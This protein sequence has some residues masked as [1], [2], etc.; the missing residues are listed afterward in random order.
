MAGSMRVAKNT[1]FLYVRMVF[2]LLV[3]LYISRVL[4]QQLGVVDYGLYNV[5][6]GIVLMLGFVNSTAAGATSRFLTFSLAARDKELY[7]YRTIFSL[8]FFI[9][10]AIAVVLV[11]VAETAGVW[12]FDHYLVIPPERVE[13]GWWVLQLSIF[14]CLIS[15]T[16]VPYNSSLIAHEHMNVYALVGVFEAVAKLAIAYALALS[17]G[18]KLIVYALLMFSLTVSVSVFYRVYCI[19][20]FGNKCRLMFCHHAKVMKMLLGYSVWDLVGCMGGIARSQGVNIMLN[21]FFGPA[22]NAAR[23]I[24]GQ[25]E[26]GLNSFTGNFQ[27]A[28]RPAIIKRYAEGDISGMLRLFYVTCEFSLILYSLLAVPILLETDS[29]LAFWLVNPPEETAI[30]I[31]LVILTY[32]AASIN[33]AIG[34]G[35]HATGDVKRLN[36]YAGTKM[37]PEMAAIWLLLYWG[38]PAWSA[39]AVMLVS[40]TLIMWVDVWVLKLN[41]PA[42]RFGEFFQRVILRAGAAVAVPVLISYGICMIL[43]WDIPLLRLILISIIYWLLLLPMV[44]FIGM[45]NEVRNYVRGQLRK[46]FGDKNLGRL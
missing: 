22:V 30:F 40:S 15:F 11:I 16:Q 18:D 23:A 33:S 14:T 3:Q 21:A 5:I 27:T 25:V 1:L 29:V 39:F 20:S 26:N 37:F 2:V 43:P 6:G 24:A 41:I 32:F 35:V 8:A 31:Q 45:D 34:I 12:Y 38:F 10:L 44:W 19:R 42:V 46:R 9:H 13:A 28:A 36:L 4:L 17:N 7:D